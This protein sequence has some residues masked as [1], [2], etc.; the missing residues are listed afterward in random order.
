ME[1]EPEYI[2]GAME[3]T[4][5]TI[6]QQVNS[7]INFRNNL[8]YIKHWIYLIIVSFHQDIFSLG[9]D[10]NFVNRERILHE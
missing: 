2:N 6:N 5:T 1:T 8:T 7:I 10:Y 3:R 9:F 4:A